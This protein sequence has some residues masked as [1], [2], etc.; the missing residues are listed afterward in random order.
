MENLTDDHIP[1][2]GFFPTPKPS[3]LIT[4]RCCAQCNHGFSLD[5]EAFRIWAAGSGITDASKWI[6]KNKVLPNSLDAKPKLR[7]NVMR[8]VKPVHVSTPHGPL[9]LVEFGFPRDRARR[10]VVRI[11][12][13]LIRTFYPDAEHPQNQFW[14]D[15]LRPTEQNHK[16][17]NA[18]TPDMIYGERGEGVFRFFRGDLNDCA[19]YTVWLLFFY[20]HAAFYVEQA[21][22]GMERL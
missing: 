18:L 9:Q 19:Q 5:D 17:L 7:T 8:Y 21:P 10:F 1:P 13:G 3:N 20:D 2:E 14:V 4:A 12:K 16:F 15:H 6:W 11:T 22:P